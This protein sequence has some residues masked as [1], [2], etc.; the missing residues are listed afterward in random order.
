[1]LGKIV[2]LRGIPLEDGF[3]VEYGIDFQYGCKADFIFANISIVGVDPKPEHYTYVWSYMVK[4]VEDGFK[5][6]VIQHAKE[7]MYNEKDMEEYLFVVIPH[8]SKIETTAKR[9][10][11]RYPTEAILEMHAGDTVKVQKADSGIF[12]MHEDELIGVGVST[13]E[14]ETYMA[15]QA[16][17]ELLLVK[18][19]R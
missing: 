8:A 14:P 18:K 3:E 1:M 11:G 17:N 5:E 4:S 15:V 13:A 19:Y 10:A 16:G 7:D 9:I 2:K 6:I 12:E